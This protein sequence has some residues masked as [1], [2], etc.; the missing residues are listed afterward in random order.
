MLYL[1]W[2]LFNLCRRLIE[3]KSRLF[4]PS[5]NRC[6]TKNLFFSLF[7]ENISC[8]FFCH[9]T[10]CSSLLTFLSSLLLKWVYHVTIS[11]LKHMSFWWERLTPHLSDLLIWRR[12]M[13]SLTFETSFLRHSLCFVM[14]S[15]RDV[16][17]VSIW[18]ILSLRRKNKSVVSILD[19]FSRS[20]F[21]PLFQTRP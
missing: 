5:D 3:S 4:M 19:W 2:K 15:L 6:K 7:W 17:F 16:S 1:T 21:A 11:V 9:L 18:A 10:F 12:R 20:W 14:C 13:V 8:A